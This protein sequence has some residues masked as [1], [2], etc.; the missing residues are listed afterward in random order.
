MS[1]GSNFQ[2]VSV[3]E[4]DIQKLGHAIIG[5][6]VDNFL[7]VSTSTTSLVTDLPEPSSKNQEI[8]SRRLSG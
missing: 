7:I 3:L 1:K 8:L 5:R 4:P 6:D 2:G